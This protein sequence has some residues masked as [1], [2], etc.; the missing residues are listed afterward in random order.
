MISE[1]HKVDDLKHNK[2]YQVRGLLVYVLKSYPSM[3][4]YLKGILKISH[5]EVHDTRALFSSTSSQIYDKQKHG[6]MKAI[7]FNKFAVD[8]ITL[9]FETS[10]Q[11]Q[12][13]SCV[14]V[15]TSSSLVSMARKEQKQ[16]QT[17]ILISQFLKQCRIRKSPKA[18][19]PTTL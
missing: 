4:P 16:W 18:P 5:I 12:V 11:I 19:D 1:A 2:L 15:H 9:L 3:N 14:Y 8:S 13:T 17:S 7:L 10:S 6:R